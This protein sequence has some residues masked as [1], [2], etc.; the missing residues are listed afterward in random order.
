MYMKKK[1][2]SYLAPYFNCSFN[3][4][5][6]LFMAILMT[7]F[8]T[9]A[10]VLVDAGR[11]NSAVSILDEAMGVSSTS[12]LADMDSYLHERWGLL[13]IEQEKS[14]DEIYS[15]YLTQNAGILGES[16]QLDNVSASGMYSL[17]EDEVLYNQIL[18]YCKLNAPTEL[19]VSIGNISS[20]SAIINR[21]DQ[22]KVIRAF[23]DTLTSTNEALDAT[24]TLLESSEELKTLASDLEKQIRKYD[25]DYTA[26]EQ[27]VSA[28]VDALNEPEPERQDYTDDDGN[29]DTAAYEKAKEEWKKAIEDAR[30]E[31]NGARDV[32]A[33]TIGKLQDDMTVYRETM[34]TCMSSLGNIGTKLTSAV[35]SAAD[36]QTKCSDSKKNLDALQKDIKNWEDGPEFDSTEDT[37]LQMK[38]WE[39]ALSKEVTENE[40]SYQI[41]K[42]EKDSLSTLKDG[43]V[44]AFSKYDDATFGTCIQKLTVLQTTVEGFQADSYTK[45]SGKISGDT[46]HNVSIASYVSAS[47]IDAYMTEQKQK[48]MGDSLKSLMDGLSTFYNS[49]FKTNVFFDPELSATIDVNFY[50]ENLGG[51][52]GKNEYEGSA[53]AVLNDIGNIMD[54]VQRISANFA[55]FRVI[56][57]VYHFIELV[58]EVIQFCQDL[59]Q[60][61]AKIVKNMAEFFTG[62]ERLYYTTYTTFNL[63]CRTDNKAS[64]LSFSGMTGYSLGKD[65]LPDQGLTS[66]PGAFDDLLA[67]IQ[68][69]KQYSKGLGDDLTF[70]GAELEY[71]LYGSESEVANQTYTFFVLYLLRLLLDLGPVTGNAEVQALASAS[72]FGYPVVL[73]LVLVAEP[74]ADTVVLANGGS[75]DLIKSTVFLTPSGLPKLMR[76]VVTVARFN[77]EQQE[78]IKSG[79]VN[80]FGATDD[81]YDYQKKLSDYEKEKVIEEE[82]NT[83]G[84]K[85]SDY[86]KEVQKFNYRKYCF[87]LM[88]VSVTKDQQLARLK[89]LIQMETLYHYNK[90]GSEAVFDLNKSY[91]YLETNVTADV[92]QLMPSLIDSSV[93]HVTRQQFRGY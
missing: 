92:K 68:S 59:I 25:E 74:L 40:I 73:F 49:I 12:T 21:L 41:I 44:E 33:E 51:L 19:A 75:I 2:K 54:R 29:V 26:F 79:F 77:A 50:N 7:P 93:F 11:Y 15:T 53:L 55:T 71:I 66:E 5:I 86:L 83:G 34:G 18:E 63:P 69:L 48:L 24:A 67:V 46:Y 4:A 78:T 22:V 90:T 58:G 28:L 80:A 30:A 85:K 43:Y 35:A 62:Y 14:V 60:F 6:S 57:M 36:L 10:M 13:G 91:T 27:A 9:V 47:E 61:V 81:D 52:E 76:E 8:L 23:M 89:N 38:D 20:I 17:A 45:N 42:A 84:G 88:L 56:S 65:S 32:Y 3:G 39:Q 70:S 37:Y 82:K 64:G 1:V 72:T 16:I 31:A 87:L